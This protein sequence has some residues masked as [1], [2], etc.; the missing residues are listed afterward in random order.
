MGY[1]LA[2]IG[3]AVVLVFLLFAVLNRRDN[4]GGRHRRKNK[5]TSYEKPQD[6][7]TPESLAKRK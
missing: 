5:G 7:G 3:I 2:T 6:E 1:V 4:G